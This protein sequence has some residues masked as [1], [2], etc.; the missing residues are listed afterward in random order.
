MA[1]KAICGTFPENGR[2]TKVVQLPVGDAK[3]NMTFCGGVKVVCIFDGGLG[4]QLFQYAFS[5]ALKHQLRDSTLEAVTSLVE[6]RSP[7]RA[8]YLR[9]L[10]LEIP[11]CRMDIQRYVGVLWYRAVCR[12]IPGI[13][14]FPG[15][16][17]DSGDWQRDLGR[18]SAIHG[19]IWLYGYWQHMRV[20]DIARD[21]LRGQVSSYT[22]TT[23]EGVQL[24]DRLLR[25]ATIAVHIRRSDYVSNHKASKFHQVCTPHYYLAGVEQ[26]R[27]DYP[28]LPLL[29][30]SDDI[31]WCQA[32]LGLRG[33]VG[34]VDPAI[35][36]L[37]QFVLLSR[38]RHFL[39]SNST[40]S[41]WAAFL[42]QSDDTI[43]IAP[44]YWFR[45]VETRGTGLYQPR[46]VY[47]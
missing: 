3:G 11:E 15:M 6:K 44:R 30:F 23:P 33:D 16:I 42:N 1:H 4:N 5:Y 9:C 40:F 46:W 37:D 26:L 36:D 12:R 25:Q 2:E 43:T 13:S 14:Y 21:L 27:R 8:F 32:E 18:A 39:I 22:P 35:P 31:K 19:H 38:C 47:M 34:F 7:K 45:G 28:K 10:G 20:A 41:W 29:V 24:S 17:L